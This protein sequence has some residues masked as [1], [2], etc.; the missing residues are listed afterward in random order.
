MVTTSQAEQ[1]VIFMLYLLFYAT[2]LTGWAVA[3]GE[4]QPKRAGHSQE[5]QS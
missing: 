2:T 4:L 5:L 1:I 3:L